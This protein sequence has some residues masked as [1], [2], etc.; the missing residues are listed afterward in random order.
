MRD[1]KEKSWVFLAAT[2][3]MFMLL[4]GPT[5]A[6]A[7]AILGR[8]QTAMAVGVPHAAGLNPGAFRCRQPP[9]HCLVALLFHLCI[10]QTWQF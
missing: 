1:L 9:Q 2:S 8:L 6:E 4:Q 3:I 5:E 10:A 7:A